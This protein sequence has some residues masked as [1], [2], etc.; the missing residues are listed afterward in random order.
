MDGGNRR[1]DGLL[2]ALS[3]ELR[4][5]LASLRS[6]L[7]VL[8][9]AVPGGEQARR[10]LAI[11]NR[12]VD[13]LTS[14]SDDLLDVARMDHDKMVLRRSAIDLCALVHT[15]VDD[16]WALFEG[17]S[18]RLVLEV[19][20]EPVP[21]LADPARLSQSLGNLLH[22]A[23]KFTP[24]GGR[25]T[26]IVERDPGTDL[27]RI[28]VRDTGAGIPPDLL[29]HVFEPFIQGDD[30]LA[31]SQGGL[32]LGLTVVKGLVELHGGS[33]HAASAGS[34]QGTTFTISLPLRPAAGT[35]L[36]PAQA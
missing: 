6:S 24:S 18:P 14:L 2:A 8:Q 17:P 32:G 3:H 21:I 4:N 1:K 15:A 5:P 35:E 29:P 36:T 9:R 33:V 23:A 28:I 13:Q 12:Q 34:G 11:M 30:S 16:N 10:M 31:R 22:N 19:P 7:Y 26:V 27:A 25:V 20:E